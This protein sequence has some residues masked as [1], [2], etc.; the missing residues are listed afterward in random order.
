MYEFTNCVTHGKKWNSVQLRRCSD[1]EARKLCRLVLQ[2]LLRTSAHQPKNKPTALPPD[3]LVGNGEKN[4]H[5]GK[6]QWEFQCLTWFTP[7]LRKPYTRQ[8]L[9]CCAMSCMSKVFTK[10]SW[11][12]LPLSCPNVHSRCA[13]QTPSQHRCLHAAVA[14]DMQS[15]ALSY[16]R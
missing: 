3:T 4:E 13:P 12:A 2:S 6:K 11:T 10:Q 7:I 14:L 9:E 16:F 5:A 8:T 15:F 1:P